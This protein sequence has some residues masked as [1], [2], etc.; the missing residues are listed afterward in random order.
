MNGYDIALGVFVWPLI[1][2]AIVGYIFIKNNS[3]VTA[4]VAIIMLFAGLGT[5]WIAG[6]SVLALFLQVVAMLS[7][8]GMILFFLVRRRG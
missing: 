4:S 6:A 1:F 5:S 3:A 7:F 8:T 2:S